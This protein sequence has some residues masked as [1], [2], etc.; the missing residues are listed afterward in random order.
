MT[1]LLRLL[2]K[3]LKAK[4]FFS[5]FLVALFG[6]LTLL[7]GLS[8]LT[9]YL[10][11]R[12]V[13][14]VPGLGRSLTA[15]EVRAS[16]SSA[17]E[18]ALLLS[19]LVAGVVGML[20]ATGVSLFV[21]GRIT[22]PVLHMLAATR[23]ISSGRYS[24]RVPVQEPDELGA[25]SESF[26]VMAT[27]LEGVE[28]RRRELMMD[29]SHE[30]R[31]PLT[32]LEGYIEGLLD[33][34]V[35]PSRDTW[36]LL[37]GEAERMRRL[38]DDLQQLSRAEAGSL[39]LNSGAVSP[40]EI[41]RCTTERCW[42][43]FAEKGVALEWE[44]T[45]GLPDVVADGDRVVQVLTNLLNNALRYTPPGGRVVL[46]GRPQGEQV[47]FTVTDTG[48][49]IAGEHLP[50]VF[51]RFYRVEKSRSRESGGSGVGLSIA[52]ALVEAMGGRIWA[53]SEGPG[54]GS[55]FAFTLP[56]TVSSPL[57]ASSR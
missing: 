31:T 21:S 45:G 57:G 56:V 6:T 42:T 13:E 40:S 32:T 25:L 11:G 26:N 19:L 43:R 17:F 29:V 50:H 20:A 44:Q 41:L 4:L 35:T 2:P 14:D 3:N 16:V 1:L 53:E 38:V 30:L 33:G 51:E 46:R 23:R 54:K 37:H 18:Q 36:T 52:R 10:F 39:S 15:E 49:G 47:L 8:F 28:R 12:L 48:E 7:V 55:T 22:R 24:E 34:V 27:S 5:H 9:P